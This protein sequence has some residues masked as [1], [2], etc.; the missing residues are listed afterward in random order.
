MGG[1]DISDS[2]YIGTYGGRYSASW[3]TH[4]N[5]KMSLHLIVLSPLTALLTV[6]WF[7]MC[8]TVTVNIV[9]V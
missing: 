2:L 4:V 5:T 9:D 1:K 8:R 3:R 6:V 7:S